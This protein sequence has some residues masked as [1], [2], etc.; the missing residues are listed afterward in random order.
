MNPQA[1]LKYFKWIATTDDAISNHRSGYKRRIS[2]KITTKIFIRVNKIYRWLLIQ[3][4]PYAI[5]C[6]VFQQE[7]DPCLHVQHLHLIFVV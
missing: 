3:P 6:A 1:W 4:L 7:F 5:V 2:N